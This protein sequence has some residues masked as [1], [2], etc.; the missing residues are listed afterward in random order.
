MLQVSDLTYGEQLVLWAARR[1]LANRSGWDRVGEEFALALGCGRARVAL[2]VL[3][4]LL[5]ALHGGARRTVYLHRL[6]CARVSGDEQA[7]LATIAALQAGDTRRAAAL[8]DCL[9]PPSALRAA[10]GGAEAL[11]DALTDAG[12]VL[13][14]RRTAESVTAC[15]IVHDRLGATL[16]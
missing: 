11:A 4:T 14:S 13:P 10:L 5:G 16:H 12:R 7:L 15:A 6:D 3:E 2:A 1:W 9:L 8:L